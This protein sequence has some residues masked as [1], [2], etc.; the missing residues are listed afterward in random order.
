MESNYQEFLKTKAKT[1]I[2]SGFDI[3]DADLNINLFPFQRFIVK[4]AL[5]AGKYAIFA[6]CG[7]GKTLMQLEWAMQVSIYTGKS[8]LVVAPLAVTGQTINEGLKFGIEVNYYSDLAGAFN[9]NLY[10]KL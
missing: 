3:Q 4:R 7:L 5:K 6:D 10:H 2:Q 1:I 9:W 8:V